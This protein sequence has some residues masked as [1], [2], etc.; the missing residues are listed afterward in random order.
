[1][2]GER[3]GCIRIAFA[4]PRHHAVAQRRATPR[5][6]EQSAWFIDYEQMLIFKHSAWVSRV[7]RR[8]AEQRRRSDRQSVEHV[9][10]NGQTF[11]TT[12]CIEHSLATIARRRRSAPPELGQ[13]DRS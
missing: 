12:R 4:K 7:N 6:R 9:R 5:N 13:R 11:S 3:A 8:T 1:M 10:E 2:H